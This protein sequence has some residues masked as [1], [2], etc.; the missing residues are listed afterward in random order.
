MQRVALVFFFVVGSALTAFAILDPLGMFPWGGRGGPASATT[1]AEDLPLHTCPMHPQVLQHGEGTCPLCAMALVPVETSEPDDTGHGGVVLDPEVVQSIGVVSEPAVRT[2]LARVA[3]T[4]GILDFNA[5]RIHWINTKFS[6]WIEK[7][8]VNY[9]GQ[10]IRVDQPL[11]EIYSPE[12]VTT[13]EEYLRAID[14]RDSLRGSRH[15]EARRQA[16][17]LLRSTRERLKNW[18]VGQEEITRLEQTRRIDRTI[19][20]RSR[21]EGVV[22]EILH[23]ALEGVFVE[24][25]RNLYKIADL[26]TVWVHADVF[27]SDL[28]WVRENQP[29]QVTFRFDPQRVYDGKVLFL[30][31]EVSPETRT[32]KLCIEVPNPS[33]TLRAG[34]YADVTIEG[35]RSRNVVVIPDSAVLR[36]GERNLVFVDEGEGR[37]APREV[38]LGMRGSGG[39]IEVR[40]GIE[41][42]ERVVTQAQFMLD[43]ESRVREAIAN[44]TAQP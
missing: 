9:V 31:P 35:P 41:A 29:A 37:F 15:V 13:Q 7:V 32:L 3:K 21:V 39:R 11:F 1:G 40:E 5:D 18:D 25:G 19:T 8:L 20:V 44:Y 36:S 38:A 26:Q 27:E 4:V 33:G 10:E 28:A 42:G 17:S 43:S 2:S 16:E 23:E 24:A 22:A 12:L 6:G 14:Y 34:M 30:Y